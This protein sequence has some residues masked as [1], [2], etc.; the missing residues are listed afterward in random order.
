MRKLLLVL[1]LYC[2]SA[3][4]AT[5]GTGNQSETCLNFIQTTDHGFLMVGYNDS[6]V[7]QVNDVYIVKTN[8]N[9]DTLWTLTMGDPNFDE[10]ATD[11][12]ELSSGFM[13]L[14]TR[15]DNITGTV[16]LI[17][18]DN[19]GREQWTSELLWDPQQGYGGFASTDIIE[20]NPNN[21]FIPMY[22]YLP[23]CGYDTVDMSVDSS[24]SFIPIIVPTV[25][26][27]TTPIATDNISY[28]A[29]V[30]SLGNTMWTYNINLSQIS[31]NFATTTYD[32]GVAVAGVYDDGNGNKDFWLMLFDNLGVSLGTK[33]IQQDNF[34]IYPNP[35]TGDF[36]ILSKTRV[37]DVVIVN[38][39]GG[40]EDRDNL[41]D[42]VYFVLTKNCIKR[43]VIQKQK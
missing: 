25:V 37:E 29:G 43:L 34:V 12:V 26:A 22:H 40:I 28:I 42:G 31:I 3:S 4:A 24:G 30:D 9:L 11:V 1:A 10:Y 8:S 36:D 15:T 19:E 7:S 20:V 39:R 41:T 16:W 33:E 5:Y 18:I 2:T 21:Y 17:K 23:C 13:I 6:P 38:Q 32:G 27:N 35:S 14:A